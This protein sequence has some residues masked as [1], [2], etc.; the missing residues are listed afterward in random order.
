MKVGDLV[1]YGRWYTGRP[2]VGLIIE[3]QGVYDHFFLVAWP[4]CLDWEGIEE[5]E[6]VGEN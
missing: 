4:D 5:L 1:K 6:V 3:S 2:K